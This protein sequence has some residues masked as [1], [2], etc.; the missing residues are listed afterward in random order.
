MNYAK[1]SPLFYKVFT[2]AGIGIFLDAADV[3]MASAINTAMMAD[4]FATVAQGS[5]FL[6]AGF[7]GLFVGSLLAGYIGDFYGRRRSY[8]F[9]LLL[10]GVFTFI[11]AFM[12]SITWMI[13]CRFF[14]AVGLGAEIVTGYAVVNEFAPVNRRG[15]WSGMIAIVANAGAPIT[16][17]IATFM[18]PNVG[19]RSMFIVM[20]IAAIILW[21]AR[22][23]FPESPR[24]LI[25]RGR[26]AEAQEIVD[27]LNVNGMYEITEKNE[28][29]RR[30]KVSFG[31][32]VFVASVAVGA[33]LLCQYT[34]TSWVPTL[35]VRRGISIFSS[36]GFSAVMMLGA[37]IGATIGTVLVER[38]GRKK[39]IV[40]TFCA[41]AIL[42]IA[43]AY[44][45]TTIGTIINGLLLTTTFYILM[46]SVISVYTNELFE[47]KYRFRGA[48]IANAVA[49]LLNV[50]MPTAVAFLITQVSPSAIF[51]GIAAMAVIA[52]AVVGFFGPETTAKEIK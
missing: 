1:E 39:L 30:V 12:P 29:E 16:L 14:A 5:M 41:T 35:L 23:N 49:K 27:Q 13:A 24:W 17:L 21:F 6:S 38:T 48:G 7:L 47:T 42:G 37:P 15:F 18:V 25:A 40:T 32:G 26:Q 11:S 31:R 45:T 3:Y 10:F 46:A 28:D 36:I 9:N 50:L 20:G 44:E 34:F 33:A 19:W 8:Q 43:Y 4:K 2:L 52:A 51:Y 22:H